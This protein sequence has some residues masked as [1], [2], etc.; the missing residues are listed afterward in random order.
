MIKSD[1]IKNKKAEEKEGIPCRGS[2][3]SDSGA[4]L[5]LEKILGEDVAGKFF[6]VANSDLSEDF[7]LPSSK[8]GLVVQKRINDIDQINRFLERC[9]GLLNHDQYIVVCLETKNT[10]KEKIFNKYPSLLSYPYYLADFIVNRVLAKLM[11]TK[12]LHRSVSKG[13]NKVITL[14][15]GLARIV[16]AGF[17]IKDYNRI[18]GLTYII[19]RKIGEPAFEP[20]STYGAIIKL[21]RV[22]KDGKIID[23]YKIRTMH[24]Y[25]EHLQEYMY[26]RFGTKDGDKIENDFRKTS[27]GKFFR[28]YWID[29]IPMIWNL[30]KGDLKLFGVRPLS[31]HKYDTYP[32]NL[33]I[34]RI[35]TKPGLIPPYYADLP[36][37]DEKFFETENNYLD[38]Y[39]EKP[40]RTDIQYFFKVL[41]NIVI[42]GQRSR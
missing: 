2:E 5:Y 40:L 10:R 14:T 26:D 35:Q 36:E 21:Q 30:L 20:D 37:T 38:K 16:C 3:I 6:W 42:R 15:E 33:Q 4:Y 9:S 7:S 24:P 11:L 18:N 41:Y 25:S 29:E 39:F 17:E 1:T 19:G 31:K 34:K 22:G 23:V 8:S 27:W 28:K 32:E 13:K 12:K